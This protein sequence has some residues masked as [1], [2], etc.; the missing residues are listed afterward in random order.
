MNPMKR[1]V[2]AL[3]LLVPA[4]VALGQGPK[5]PNTQPIY[6]IPTLPGMPLLLRPEVQADLKL[7]AKQK[8][9]IDQKV[10]AWMKMEREK[11]ATKKIPPVHE[12]ER[13]V[14]ATL[15]PDQLARLKQLTI[16]RQG[17]FAISSPD[18][19]KQLGITKAQEAKIM[20]VR[21]EGF[22]KHMAAA[23][24]KPGYKADP[25]I[26]AW[27]KEGIMKVLTPAQKAKWNKIIGKPIKWSD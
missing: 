25:K 10:G 6:E 24:N 7:D 9:V 27:I 3:L 14:R 23:K 21:Q 20:Q 12:T 16:Q 4:C 13:I 8:G 5:E 18:I 11:R 15:R 2:F 19:A 22:Q 1:A 17:A 26:T